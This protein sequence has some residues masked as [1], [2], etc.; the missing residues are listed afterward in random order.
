M[1]TKPLATLREVT[2]LGDMVTG[3]VDP[4]KAPCPCRAWKPPAWVLLSLPLL[5]LPSL[6]R[7]L[8]WPLPLAF[9]SDSHLT[10][11]PAFLGTPLLPY[12]DPPSQPATLFLTLN[13]QW[14]CPSYPPTSASWG[15][16]VFKIPGSVR[17]VF[18]GLPQTNPQL[19]F[20]S[21]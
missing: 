18:L 21:W 13:L 19:G 11:S 5:F 15:T 9:Q 14:V 10:F 17:G 6:F 1:L 4:I 20:N 7:R 3:R 12:S 2:A 16:Q 8:L